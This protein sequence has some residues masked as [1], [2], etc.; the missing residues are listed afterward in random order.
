MTQILKKIPKVM[1][2]M[3]RKN[4]LMYVLDRNRRE[5]RSTGIVTYDPSKD[6]DEDEKKDTEEKDKLLEVHCEDGVTCSAM[7]YNYNRYSLGSYPGLYSS[8]G[9]SPSSVHSSG[10]GSGYSSRSGSTNSLSSIG[11]SVGHGSTHSYSGYHPPTPS[12]YTPYL[13]N[14]YSGRY[15]STSDVGTS[16]RYSHR[17]D[18]P[19]SYIGS[20]SSLN[21][22]YKKLYEDEKANT[23]RLKKDLEA[24]KKEL[25]ESKAELDRLIKRNEVNR[26]ADT[27]DKREKRALERKLSELEEELKKMEVLK[28]DNRRLKEENGALIRVISK[29]SK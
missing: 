19:S 3:K 20:T 5:R 13:R 4:P 1:I 12:T 16:D 6:D 27:N 24:V 8:Y 2:K 7:S 22:D 15:N 14:S 18:R 11:S 29:L 28:E 17:T 26:L 9:S 21:L 10:I 23:E 25:I